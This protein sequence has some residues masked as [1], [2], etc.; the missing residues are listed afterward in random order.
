MKHVEKHHKKHKK[1]SDEGKHRHHHHHH[2]QK[3]HHKHHHKHIHS[4]HD[5]DPVEKKSISDVAIKGLE[6]KEKCDIKNLKVQTSV[7]IGHSEEATTKENVSIAG[8]DQLREKD[9]DEIHDSASANRNNHNNSFLTEAIQQV[10]YKNGPWRD[11]VTLSNQS[12]SSKDPQ[13]ESSVKDD[14]QTANHEIKSNKVTTNNQVDHTMSE[15]NSKSK[16]ESLQNCISQ[17]EKEKVIL[18]V[19]DNRKHD[20]TSVVSELRITNG[21]EFKSHRKR[22]DQASSEKTERTTEK[23][24]SSCNRQ[25][26]VS[27][28]E[29]KLH[30]HSQPSEKTET[31]GM[32]NIVKSS[33]DK[34]NNVVVGVSV[35]SA[36]AHKSH[37]HGSSDHHSHR[38]S[39]KG[40]S[41]LSSD[42]SKSHKKKR[43]VNCGVQVNLDKKKTDTKSSQVPADLNADKLSDKKL[44]P[45][46]YV[47][48]NISD[49]HKVKTP[50]KYTPRKVE[51]LQNGEKADGIKAEYYKE[52]VSAQTD[53]KKWNSNIPSISR[54]KYK[55]LMHVEQYS[56]GGALVCHAYQDEV[57][58]LDKTEKKEFA[59]EFMDFVYG[60]IE[61][62]VANCCMGIVHGAIRD[63]PDLVEFMAD[64]YPSMTVKAGSMG[65]SDIETM[66]M[67]KYREQV[68]KSYE[69]GTFRCGP[70]L[71]LSLVGTAQEE[72]GD[73]FPEILDMLE[74]D[75]FLDIVM[76]WGELSSV[77][78]ASRNHSNDGPI[79]WV[80]PGEQM[81]P[82]ADMPKSPFKRKR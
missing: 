59:R 78:M 33:S 60:E 40:R 29:N 63:M 25:D 50:L 21:T 79:L 44:Q 49:S 16:I 8:V 65:K 77:R 35:S 68:H 20:D 72:V 80:R 76:P 6:S 54:C 74:N 64:N 39:S 67:D 2:K 46:A 41:E 24:N 48:Q 28:Q 15:K 75:P 81:I 47:Q 53:G 13:R 58:K 42:K 45:I 5:A 62:G 17:T 37:K 66:A 31:K 32:T 3:S 11:K 19:S 1:S 57:E 69:A 43:I 23:A 36:A 7:E 9:K 38:S 56:N 73:Y 51:N 10:A 26:Y 70:L 4:K 61:E 34:G 18:K 52:F 27:E 12:I 55:D 82:T 22:D 30:K 14:K 71:Q